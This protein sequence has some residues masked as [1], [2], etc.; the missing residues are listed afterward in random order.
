M[1]SAWPRGFARAR[2]V[3]VDGPSSDHFVSGVSSSIALDLTSS[4]HVCLYVT[5]CVPCLLCSCD[6]L[7]RTQDMPIPQLSVMG[8]QSSGKSSVLEFLSGIPFPRGSGLVT[9]CATQ[10]VGPLCSRVLCSFFVRRCLFALWL[11]FCSTIVLLCGL[12]HPDVSFWRWYAHDAV[13][14]RCRL[15]PPPP[16]G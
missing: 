16:P 2:V 13:T 5:C 6:P 15:L 12:A 4:T 3:V 9:R 7:L 8:D 11:F 14:G 10:Y 1:G